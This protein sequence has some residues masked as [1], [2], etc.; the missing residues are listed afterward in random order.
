ML[1]ILFLDLCAVYMSVFTVFI[2]QYVFDLYIFLY[3]I[4]Q[5][6]FYIKNKGWMLN[7]SK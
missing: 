3:L 7:I 1:V 5:Y 4:L 2:E 6:S